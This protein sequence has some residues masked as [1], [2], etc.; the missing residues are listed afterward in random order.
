MSDSFACVDGAAL[1]R[2]T[3]Y[4]LLSGC[5]VPRPIAWVTT[6]SDDG[7]VN[8]APFSAYS[9]VSTD[10]PMVAIS[11]ERSPETGALKDTARNIQA[12]GQFVVNV[13]DESA[14]ELLHGSAASY[15]AE[16][17]ETDVLDLP[18]IAS[19][20]IAVPRLASTAIQMECRLDQSIALGNGSNTLYIGQVVAFHLASRVYDGS[21][22]NSAALRPIA[23][24]GGP[25]YMS[26]GELHERQAAPPPDRPTS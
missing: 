25:W 3:S 14:L 12:N 5:V 2:A 15:P 16:V 21:R 10:P 26:L 23:R 9:Y 7:L 1:D 22:V 24:L 19:K 6:R 8:A 4:R 13:A 11:I 18:L 20:H 17:S